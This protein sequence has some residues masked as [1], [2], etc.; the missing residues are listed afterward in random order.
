[1]ARHAHAT[2]AHIT[3][4]AD[5]E[6]LFIEVQDNGVGIPD[7]PEHGRK[8]LGLRGMRERARYVHGTVSVEGGPGRG[9]T[10]TLEV[11]LKPAAG[12]TSE[13]A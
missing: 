4:V 6:R 11:A 3:Y 8:S 12:E 7:A 1:V 5:D 13:V 10:V 2:E 9:T